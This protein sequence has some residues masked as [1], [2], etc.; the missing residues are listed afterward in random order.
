MASRKYKLVRSGFM[1]L[2]DKVVWGKDNIPVY[3]IKALRDIPKMN[4]KK[5]DLGGF[6]TSKFTLSQEGDC[7][8]G[9]NADV[10]GNVSV[11]ENAY[12]GG[13]ANVY[14]HLD[15]S[16]LTIGGNAEI[17]NEALVSIEHDKHSGEAHEFLIEGETYIHGKARIYNVEYIG[18]NAHIS[19]N[20]C[21]RGAK[22]IS[23]KASIFGHVYI[24]SGVIIKGNSRIFDNA[25]LDKNTQIFSATVCG[26]YVTLV[27]QK[28]ELKELGKP[29]FLTPKAPKQKQKVLANSY[30]SAKSNYDATKYKIEALEK[31]NSTLEEE[32]KLS[33]KTE[34]EV[35]AEFLEEL[36]KKQED[37]A[38]PER[39]KMLDE[40]KG[41]YFNQK[42]VKKAVPTQKDVEVSDALNLLKEIKQDIFAYESD[43]VKIIKYPVMT[44]R[45]DPFTLEMAVALKLAERLALNPTHKD[46]IGAVKDLEKKFMAAESNA[47][48]IASSR[49]TDAEKKKTA[50]ARDLFAVAVN[51]ASSEN[52]KK[53]AFIQG[54][55]QLE[56]V[57]TV[58]EIAV[59]TFRI[60][61]G[62][63]ELEMGF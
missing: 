48:R 37:L 32:I 36:S 61:V 19:E 5:G 6:V 14:C 55:K 62:L 54:F 38:D 56:S 29:K 25:Y 11:I 30:S 50:K 58:P 26:D 28:V 16:V 40:V 20:A 1:G 12:I 4:V 63:P 17:R 47:V 15:D 45:T 49:L 13:N 3:Q 39:M 23:G 33:T 27:D 59:E 18:G 7:W 8:I 57:V 31:W 34:D 53:M 43:I 44:D 2:T 60:K 46:F 22:H 24:G 51:E 41:K 21:I 52:E 10:L 42:S 9:E 35:I